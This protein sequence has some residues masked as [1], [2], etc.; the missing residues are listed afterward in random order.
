MTFSEYFPVWQKLSDKQRTTIESN[1]FS[2]FVEKGTILHN[3]SMDCTGLFLIKSGQLRAYILSDE[4][5][6][7]TIYRLF[8]RDLCLF[9]ASCMMNS[10][11]FDI[12]IEAEKDSEVWVIPV[13]IYKSIMEESAPV[14]N[15]TNEIMASRFSEVMWLIEQIMWKSLDKRVAAFLLEE[16]ALE[17]SSQ[18]RIT[19]E[20]IANH[21]GTHR[22]V[23]TRM[24]KY[25]QNE[26]MVRL[27][28]G[29]I[30]VLN[31]KAL[32]SLADM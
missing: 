17:N 30:E 5:R 22:E 20:V 3:G 24:L 13:E 31:E 26:G 32:T 4:G 2:R 18:L 6:E 11:Q 16:T 7:I 28:R 19:H 15:Y 29:T 21:L 1:I 10:L 8:E 27:S 23:I 9:S 14:A 12:S 25:F